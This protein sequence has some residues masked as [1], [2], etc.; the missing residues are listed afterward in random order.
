MS[1]NAQKDLFDV[2]E[3]VAINT[4]VITTIFNN[5]ETQW[6]D[7]LSSLSME[8]GLRTIEICQTENNNRLK[9]QRC[10]HFLL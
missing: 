6:L 3:V 8:D 1:K 5:E 9:K 10:T 4:N 7:M 2:A